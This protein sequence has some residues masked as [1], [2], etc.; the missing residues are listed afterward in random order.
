MLESLGI[1]GYRAKQM[2][3][4]VYKARTAD[5][6]AMTDLSARDRGVIAEN[7]RF[8]TC[9]TLQHQTATDGVQKLLL[10][11][12]DHSNPL[13]VV[14][15]STRQTECV[16]IPAEA[17]VTQRPRLTACVSSQVGCPVGCKFCASGLDGLDENLTAGQIVEQVWHL[18]RLAGPRG[19]TNVVMMGMGEPLA[20]FT[21][22]VTA[23]RMLTS[24]WGPNLSARRITVSTVGLPAQIRRLADTR[25]PVTLAI[26]LHAPNDP[27]RRELIPWAKH[28]SIDQLVD[29]GRYFFRQTGREVT[30]EYTLMADVND[31]PEH[32]RQLARVAGR[33]RS[34]VNLIR[35]NEV[36]SLPYRRP[37]GER[38]YRFQSI[39]QD[40]GVK[41]NVRASR[42]RDI[43]AACGQLRHQEAHSTTRSPIA[44][45][46]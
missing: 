42:G 5:P 39:L 38:T 25:I 31:H 45:H 43:A 44:S 3:H 8:V 26:S 18:S 37:N 13:A 41:T 10:E 1:A 15:N 30:L 16:L 11:W 17:R 19:V 23:L 21:P 36:A 22:V 27:L 12:T 46:A 24:R 32:A 4:W 29:A 33:L 14:G 2:M 20:N 7:I 28:V 34:K 35:Y 6:A 40:S 9:H